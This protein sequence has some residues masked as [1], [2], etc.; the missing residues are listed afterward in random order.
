MPIDISSDGITE[1][2]KLNS[3][4]VW[5]VLLKVEYPG[6]DPG[7]CCLNNEQITWNSLTWLPVIFSLSGMSETKEAEI[8]MVTLTVTDLARSLLPFIEE[9]GGGI[10]AMVTIYIVHSAHLD[11]A[12][13]EFEE[14]MEVIDTSV[15]NNYKITIKLGAE[16]L[17]KSRCPQNRY[18]KNHC[19]YDGLDDDRCGYSGAETECDRTFTRCKELGREIYYGGQPGVGAMGVQL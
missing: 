16:N 11:N 6:E 9:Q 7:Y 5:L 19:R 3:D 17:M 10:G 12:T 14:E 2:N 15:K 8:P 1:K 18:L 13:P 4:D